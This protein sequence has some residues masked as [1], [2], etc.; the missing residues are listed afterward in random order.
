MAG[1]W[2]EWSKSGEIPKIIGASVSKNSPSDNGVTPPMSTTPSNLLDLQ[3][4]VKPARS[5][6]LY[7]TC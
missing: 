1:G 6:P 5:T 4:P 2:A 3:H 7:E